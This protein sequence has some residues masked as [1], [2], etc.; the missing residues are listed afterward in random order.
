MKYNHS[1]LVELILPCAG[2][3][4][5]C[6]SRGSDMIACLGMVE[7]LAYIVLGSDIHVH[8]HVQTQIVAMATKYLLRPCNHCHEMYSYVQA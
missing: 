1:P 5:T 2:D 3:L 6:V 7:G 4:Y 8:V